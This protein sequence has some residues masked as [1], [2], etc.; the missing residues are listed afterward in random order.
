[1]NEKDLFVLVNEK[2]IL[3]DVPK[4]SKPTT[5]FADALK[6]FLKNKSSLVAFFFISFLSFFAVVLPISS[7]NNP[8][9]ANA[10]FLPPRWQI[11][12]GSG[13]L[14]GTLTY[15]G[16]IIDNTDPN[17]LI[18]IGF[19][20]TAIVGDIE[21]FED[22]TNTQSPYAFGGYLSLRPD[23]RDVNLT[24]FSPS[25]NIDLTKNI[26][27][28]INIPEEVNTT[29]NPANLPR[30]KFLLDLNLLGSNYS[31]TIKDV[32]SDFGLIEINVNEE[33][34]DLLTTLDLS[35]NN[36]SV[37]FGIMVLTE[38]SPLVFPSLFVQSFEITNSLLDSNVF[39]SIN[40]TD[41]NSL[42]MRDLNP[43]LAWKIQSI[44][45]SVLVSSGVK[46]VIDAKILRGNFKYNPYLEVFGL[47]ERVIGQSIILDYIQKGWINYSF[48]QGITSFSLTEAGEE[49]S[50]LRVVLSQKTISALGKV[51]IEVSGIISMYRFYGFT[52]MPYYYFG[53]DNLGKDFLIEVFAGLRTSL[54]LGLLVTFV[55]VMFGIL[56]G[57]ISGYFGGNVDLYMER[58]TEILG[59]VPWIIILTLAI[60]LLG[61]SFITFIIALTLTGWI[62]IAS[63]TRSQFYR[64]KRR[65][66]VLASRTLGAKDGRLIFR[67]IL[68]NAIGPIITSSVLLIPGVIFA[69]A[70]I[71][72]LGLGFTSLPSLGVALS[73][74]QQFLSSSPYLTYSGS[75]V[76]SI[77]MISFNLFGNGLRDAF[78]PSLKG[79]GE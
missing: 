12:E 14:D 35:L 27:F 57:S 28:K 50:P 52:E 29:R 65:E 53:T 34:N 9:I 55:N 79:I 22:V 46:N 39:S 71:S 18:P 33:I 76:I 20:Q 36:L 42:M 43:N 17:K 16:I 23:N 78:N 30:Y 31:L 51:T 3:Q 15:S 77:I 7:S 8:T 32:S 58:F 74:G 6:R 72:F 19:D 48:D 62:G 61:Q 47:K 56:W 10:R 40:F 63:L 64:Y 54:L 67:H 66:Y 26:V 59:G 41:G 25:F 5:F 2:K 75:L 60:L 70:T 49:Y 1:M 68:P 45:D 38:A 69:E 13:I 44:K 37:A 11:F 4:A 21:V 24:I 73:N